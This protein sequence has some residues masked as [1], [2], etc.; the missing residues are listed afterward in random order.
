MNRN[1]IVIMLSVVARR[2]KAHFA[3]MFQGTI[4]KRDLKFRT[5]HFQDV[6]K[7]V[8]REIFPFALM[9]QVSS[10]EECVSGIGKGQKLPL[11]RLKN[12]R[13]NQRYPVFQAR[14]GHESNYEAGR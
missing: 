11:P 5:T 13:T 14:K 8:V 7:I 1:G 6:S 2:L 10:G 4:Q 9:A 12:S 3:S